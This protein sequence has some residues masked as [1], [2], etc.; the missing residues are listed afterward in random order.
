MIA[1]NSLLF[2]GQTSQ[3]K[4]HK[5]FIAG[6]QIF[7]FVLLFKFNGELE[8]GRMILESLPISIWSDG[9]YPPAIESIGWPFSNFIELN[10][11]MLDLQSLI[12]YL[13]IFTCGPGLIFWLT[14]R[15][16]RHDNWRVYLVVLGIQVLL[17]LIGWDW[18]R[19]ISL[20]AFCLVS[21]TVFNA[22]KKSNE[23]ETPTKS[24]QILSFWKI[25]DLALGGVLLIILLSI[26]APSHGPRPYF[27][28]QLSQ[29]VYYVF[30]IYHNK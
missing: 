2:P 20:I 23:I 25:K 12:G 16:S 19:W 15:G 9:I 21:L 28:F 30:E 7:L 17:F 4:I 5:Y 26:Q 6:T 24:Q 3:L 27:G 1:R 18:G 14:L 11:V 22:E 13:V 10:R 29:L 8:S